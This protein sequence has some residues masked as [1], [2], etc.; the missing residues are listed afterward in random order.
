MEKKASYTDNEKLSIRL[1]KELEKNKKQSIQSPFNEQ[2]ISIDE[3][4]NFV[5]EIYNNS[6]PSRQYYE[7]IVNS[8]N[9]KLVF[10]SGTP[11]INRPSE[12][13]ILCNM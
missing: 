5:R 1:L 4:H 7:W 2:V 8:E 10:L 6:G 12:I 3:V 11:L 13:A 9:V